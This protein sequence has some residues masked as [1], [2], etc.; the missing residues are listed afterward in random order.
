[1]S[2]LQIFSEASKEIVV[3]KIPDQRLEERKR[4]IYR[5]VV[6]PNNV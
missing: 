3:S 1:M 5:K 2:L 4:K 6:G